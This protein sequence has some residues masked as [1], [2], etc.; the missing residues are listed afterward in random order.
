[1]ADKGFNIKIRE[2]ENGYTIH[3]NKA[4]VPNDSDEHKNFVALDA[5][6]AYE[7]TCTYMAKELGLDDEDKT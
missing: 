7:L 3:V 1:M 4:G 5:D 2:V 6:D